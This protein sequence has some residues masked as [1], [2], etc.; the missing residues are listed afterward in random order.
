MCCISHHLLSL[1][2]FVQT[3]TYPEIC[4]PCSLTFTS[5]FEKR[6]E[7]KRREEK[8]REEKRREEKRR[9]EKRREHSTSRDEEDTG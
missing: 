8:R 1:S 7:E 9:E 2:P 4:Y 5:N 3:R 6:R